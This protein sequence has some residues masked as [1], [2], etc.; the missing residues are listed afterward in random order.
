MR[1]LYF[2]E[3]NARND[4]PDNMIKLMWVCTSWDANMRPLIT[5]CAEW[6]EK[7]KE[8]AIM[9]Y[10]PTLVVD[11]DINQMTLHKRNDFETKIRAKV[12]KNML[13]ERVADITKIRKN[14]SNISLSF[15]NSS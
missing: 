9:T 3:I 11:I 6:M 13:D 7:I 14:I 10:N 5:E 1:Q 15:K 2:D 8:K 4:T 12:V